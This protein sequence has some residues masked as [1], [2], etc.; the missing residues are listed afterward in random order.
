MDTLK[1]EKLK[2]KVIIFTRDFK[3]EGEIHLLEGE[4]VTDFLCSL[5]HKQFIPVTNASIFKGDS[6]KILYK[7]GYLG[8]NKDEIILLVPKDQIMKTDYFGR[9]KPEIP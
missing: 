5:H 6:L 7:V 1:R 2:H 4:R 8:L 3:L 9:K